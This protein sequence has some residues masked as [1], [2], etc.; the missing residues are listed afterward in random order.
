MLGQTF[1]LIDIARVCSLSF[2]EILLSSDNAV[3]LA[4]L[5]RALPQPLR[6]RALYIG[7][8]SAFFFRAVAILLLSFIL[9]SPWIEL[10]GAAYLIYLS[11]HYFTKKTHKKLPTA[12]ASFWK[13]VLLI[14]FFDLTFAFDSIIAGIAFIDSPSTLS[15]GLFHPKLWIVYTGG[16]IGLGF[17]RYAADL[18]SRILDRLPH[19]ETSA[20][21]LVG[22]IGIKLALSATIPPPGLEYLFW[23]AFAI[24]LGSSFFKRT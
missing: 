10:L 6:Q 24:I 15:N 19:L 1:D 2:I 17:I 22:L 21:L 16:M 4:V 11:I 5:S 3:I 7:L 23:T 8:A 12:P 20:Y 18:F 9:D 13:T 14:E